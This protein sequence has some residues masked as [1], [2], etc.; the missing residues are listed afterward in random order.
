M[1]A[2]VLSDQ[3]A[4]IPVKNPQLR[5]RGSNETSALTSKQKLETQGSAR[6]K[7]TLKS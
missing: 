5:E 7:S 1:N 3:Y 2:A 6:F 4:S